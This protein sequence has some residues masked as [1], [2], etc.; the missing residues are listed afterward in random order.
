[1]KTIFTSLDTTARSQSFRPKSFLIPNTMLGLAVILS[2]GLCTKVLAQENSQVTATSQIAASKTSS[3]DARYRIGAG[4]VLGII[5]RKSPELS[6]EAVRV[7]QRGMIRIP[8]IDEAVPAAC[9]T[10]S[11]LADNISTLYRQYKN[12]PNVA[13]FVRDFQSRPVAVIGAVNAPGQFRLQRQVR[14]LELLSFAGGPSP[15]AGRI[16]NVIHTGGPII[17][18]KDPSEV[19]ATSAGQ[20]LGIIQ[21][22]DTLK[23]K[24]GAN[25]FVQPGDIIQLPEADQVYVIGHVVQPRVIALKDKAITVSWAIAMA[26]GASRDGRTSRVRIIREIPSGGKQEIFVDLGAIQK[27]KAIDIALVPNDI[28][29]VGSSTGK[30]ILGILQ[31]AVPTAI[32]QGAVRII[33]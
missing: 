21:L 17:C 2:A 33:P 11:E 4:D 13:V 19:E 30:T 27:Q 10:E 26:G 22:N 1:M 6:M 32:T 16:I 18:Q 25:P 8:M 31:G 3:D 20:G 24:E 15:L 9:K 14:L 12:N 7:D 23:G 28:V 5:V 29:E